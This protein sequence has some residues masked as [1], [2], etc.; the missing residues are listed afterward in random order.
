MKKIIIWSLIVALLLGLGVGAFL[1]FNNTDNTPDDDT[2]STSNVA[3]K[4]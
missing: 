2:P 3:T 1:Y 4:A